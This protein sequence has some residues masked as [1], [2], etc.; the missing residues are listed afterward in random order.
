MG[1]LMAALADRYRIEHELG[2]GGMATVY[3]AHD[4]K[5]DRPVALKT[6]H[7]E[8]ASGLGRERFLRE[9]RLTARLQH[10]HILPIFDSGAAGGAREENSRLWYT[11]PYVRGE[12]LRARLRREAQLPVDT[13]LEIARQAALALEYA[14]REGAV[15]RDIKPENIL[16]SEGQSL[17]ADFGIAR[18]IGCAGEEELTVTGLAIGTPL[19]MSPEQASGGEVDGRADVYALACVLYEMLAGEP[20]FG[21]STPQ[22]IIARRFAGEPPS[23]RTVRPTVPEAVDVAIQRALALVPG[24]RFGS[25]AQF[26]AALAGSSQAAAATPAPARQR[27]ATLWHRRGVVGGAL[28][29]ILLL[30]GLGALLARLL[31]RP[32]SDAA[33]SKRLAVLPFE[34]LGRPENAYLVDG[35]TDEV[36]GKL[37]GLRTLQVIARASSNQYRQTRKLPQQIARELGVRYLVTGT[38]RSVPAAAGRRARIRVQPELVEV[39]G[40]ATPVSRWEQPFDAELADVFQLQADLA[41]RIAE[42]LH[43]EFGGAEQARLAE[44]PTASLAAYDAFLQGE[45]ASNGLAEQSTP[46][47]LRAIDLYRRAVALDSTFALG[48]ARLAAARA[49]LVFNAAGAAAATGAHAEARS[50]AERALTL[51]PSLP[52]AR[53]AMGYY[54]LQV[55]KNPARA[56]EQFTVGL[57]L[58]PN[59]AELLT[60]AGW[61]EQTLA[62]GE[63]AVAH[64]RRATVIDPRSV[65]PARWLGT[66]LLWLRRYPEARE[67]FERA[68]AI[69]PADMAT[70]HDRA[71]VDLAQGDLSGARA[72][73]RRA[74]KEVDPA[75]MAAIMGWGWDLGWVLDDAGQRLL[76]ALGP[77]TFAGDRLNWGLTLAQVHDFRGEKRPARVYADSARIAGAKALRDAPKDPQLHALYG[78]ALGYLGRR[79][80]AVREGERAVSLLPVTKD[81]FSG[82]YYQH[83]LVRIYILV[84]EAEAALDRLE[85]LLRRP[86]YLSPAW[87]RID[88]TFIPLRGNPRFERL[89]AEK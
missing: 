51:A 37:A 26:A 29:A 3:L 89:A 12:S 84:D 35:I 63:A 65:S 1:Q 66:V 5:H 68:L 87:L 76:L 40:G 24:D 47:L 9:I 64:L 53:L 17:L 83:Q 70:L 50:A 13:A 75:A 15:H 57:R 25:A 45:H 81:A 6:L 43:V 55:E 30:V 67:A 16:L 49:I 7:P 28:L 74:P 36:R 56:V 22:A 80:E 8:I 39:R 14:H 86:Y 73:L 88:P 78:V 2:R 11:M 72:V 58:T 52:D 77:E 20:P 42:G 21:G 61:A 82:A 59:D 4:L 23:V 46:A 60:A 85:P 62:Q 54:Y 32:A 31:R 69:A 79:S 48:W 41:Q 19:Y 18:A 38:V 34:N 10:P 27:Q 44:R 71:M 33:G